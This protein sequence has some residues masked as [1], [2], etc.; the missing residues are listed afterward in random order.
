MGC[1]LGRYA[2]PDNQPVRANS[3][4]P[5]AFLRTGDI[6][7]FVDKTRAKLSYSHVGVVVFLPTIYPNDPIMILECVDQQKTTIAQSDSMLGEQEHDA[8][9]DKLTNQ[10]A[11]DGVV[12]LVSLTTR[13]QQLPKNSEVL[14]KLVHQNDKQLEIQ[15]RKGGVNGVSGGF[16]ETNIISWINQYQGQMRTGTAVGV[17]FDFLRYLGISP[18]KAPRRLNM[19]AIVQGKIVAENNW[20]TES[21][22]SNLKHHNG[23]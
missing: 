15:R 8:L 13:L 7:L 18:E 5:V 20:S 16:N 14:L 22:L 17:T 1:C 4:V 6:V 21:Q 10:N 23:Y 2:S 11:P 3:G 9:V 19:N 12:R